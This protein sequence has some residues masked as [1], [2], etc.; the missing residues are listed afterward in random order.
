MR[1][2][3]ERGRESRLFVTRIDRIVDFA[4]YEMMKSDNENVRRTVQDLWHKINGLCSQARNVPHAVRLDAS[5]GVDHSGS[6]LL[7]AQRHPGEREYGSSGQIEC[8]AVS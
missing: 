6:R 5:R 7:L 3:R 2:E 1:G 4:T 8:A